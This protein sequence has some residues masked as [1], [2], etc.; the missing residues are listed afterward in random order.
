MS[1]STSNSPSEIPNTPADSSL[2][3]S[4]KGVLYTLRASLVLAG[5]LITWDAVVCGSFLLS[6]CIIPI[7]VLSALVKVIFGRTSCRIA[8]AR[9]LVPLVTIGIV[10]GNAVFQ[11][12]L[13][14][15]NANVLIK[16]CEQYRRDHG[17]Y[18]KEIGSLVP[19][20]VR[21][22]PRAKQS[23]AFGH[24]FYISS[25]DSHSLMWME[26]PPFGRPCYNFEKSQWGLL[27]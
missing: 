1:P 20:Y 25:N 23:L 5:C 24:F 14:K 10:S 15:K 27:D 6:I 7:W 22:V 21:S 13:A 9:I 12:S 4:E 19:Q 16:A 2:N 3:N 26:T 17:V 11:S 8:V 18:P